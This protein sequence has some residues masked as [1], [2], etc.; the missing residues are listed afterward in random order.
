MIPVQGLKEIRKQQKAKKRAI[1]KQAIIRYM[2][3]VINMTY[4]YKVK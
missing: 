3:F 4:T 1:S 2:L